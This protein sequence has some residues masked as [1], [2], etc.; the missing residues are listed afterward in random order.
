MSE[1]SIWKPLKNKT[2]TGIRV[3]KDR[4]FI[5]FE[6]DGAALDFATYGDCCSTSWIEHVSGLDALRAGPVLEVVA[7]ELT[8]EVP[9][10]EP[11][12]HRDESVQQYFYRL[13]TTGG[14]CTLEMRNASNGYYG[15][16]MT[17]LG[18]DTAAFANADSVTEDF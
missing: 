1:Y 11:S 17:Y 9:S 8:P 6:T 16:G 4:E 12:L 2:V 7:D 5:R 15:G 3:S 10:D 13:R 14:T 18:K